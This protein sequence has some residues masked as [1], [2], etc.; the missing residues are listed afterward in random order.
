VAVT[1]VWLIDWLNYRR[2]FDKAGAE[3]ERPLRSS[4]PGFAEGALGI[5]RCLAPSVLKGPRTYLFS[6]ALVDDLQRLFVAA[7]EWQRRLP[8]EQDQ[9][10]LRTALK[11]FLDN[12]Q[13]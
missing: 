9:C 7:L 12:Q 2:L 5:A 13:N 6:P 10:S 4:L 8:F 3:L 1:Q 11:Y